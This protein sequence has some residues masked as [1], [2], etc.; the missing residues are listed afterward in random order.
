M[1]G[2]AAMVEQVR[3]QL[4]KLVDVIKVAD[5][6][7][8]GTIIRELALIKVKALLAPAAKSCR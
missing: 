8:E 5:V 1:V 6:N 7:G 4:E 2:T 3:K